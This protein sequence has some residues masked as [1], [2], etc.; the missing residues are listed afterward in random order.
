MLR[1]WSIIHHHS[2]FIIAPYRLT[3]ACTHWPR[4]RAVITRPTKYTRVLH[5]CGNR[6]MEILLQLSASVRTPGCGGVTA[7][8]NIAEQFGGY[9]HCGRGRLFVCQNS[10]DKRVT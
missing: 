7:H 6:I 8:G 3:F 10:E 5:R 4:G 9:Y 2:S 1:R